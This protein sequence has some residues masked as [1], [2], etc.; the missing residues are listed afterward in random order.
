MIG[1]KSFQ[2]RDARRGAELRVCR[3]RCAARGASLRR[4]R[5]A[6]GDGGRDRGGRRSGGGSR[7]LS[8]GDF[9]RRRARHHGAACRSAKR[10][11][12]ANWSGGD[13]RAVDRLGGARPRCPAISLQSSPQQAPCRTT[14]RSTSTA[15][16]SRSVA[17]SSSRSGP[18]RRRTRPFAG[19]AGDAWPADSGRRREIHLALADDPESRRTP[20]AKASSS[21][22]SSDLAGGADTIVAR[23]TP[24]GRGALALIR[25][26]GRETAKR[27]R[28]RSARAVRFRRGWKATPDNPLRCCRVSPRRGAVVT[29]FPGPRSYTGEDMLEV[30]VHGSPYLGR[31]GD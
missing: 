12:R 26:S 3:S 7:S 31:G 22:L 14:S 6:D 19:R 20:M 23:A 24:A 16:A 21:G 5:T 18:R 25:V 15:T 30:T 17:R 8:V 29:S 9:S 11:S 10:P 2:G 4:G 13:L 1:R 28:R 27:A